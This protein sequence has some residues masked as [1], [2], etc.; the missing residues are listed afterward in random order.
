MALIIWMNAAWSFFPAILI[1]FLDRE[2]QINLV[3][4]AALIGHF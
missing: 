2:Q 3:N 1:W 4:V